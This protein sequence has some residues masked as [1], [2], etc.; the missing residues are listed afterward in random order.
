M[1]E[2][3]QGSEMRGIEHMAGC[4]LMLEEIFGILG[5]RMAITTL[6]SIVFRPVGKEVEIRN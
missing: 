2:P 5:D 3:L 4:S 1:V 6:R